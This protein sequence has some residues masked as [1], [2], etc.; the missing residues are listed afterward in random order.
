MFF[1]WAK[2]IPVERAMDKAKNG[3]GKVKLDDSLHVIGI[4]TSFLKDF[5]EGD[6]IRFKNDEDHVVVEEQI[7]ERVE[8]DS[9]LILKKPGA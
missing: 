6:T 5:S 8:S 2:S 1:R 9:E 4:N 3:P 7:I